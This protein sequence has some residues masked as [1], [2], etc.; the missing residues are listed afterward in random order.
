MHNIGTLVSLVH[1]L[2]YILVSKKMNI[3]YV[4]INFDDT[5]N[6]KTEYI[7][8]DIYYLSLLYPYSNS[9]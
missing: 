8:F 2:F 4:K 3:F 7:Y 5:K 9:K 1:T 6:Y